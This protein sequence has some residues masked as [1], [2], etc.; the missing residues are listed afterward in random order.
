MTQICVIITAGGSGTRFNKTKKKQ[1]F[2]IFD[3]SILEWTVKAFYEH[4]LIENIIISSPKEDIELLEN[5]LRIYL[6]KV[7]LTAGGKTRQESVFNGL[8]KCPADTKIVLI[9]DA[10]RPFV[11]QEEINNLINKAKLEKAVIPVTKVK[12]TIKK[13]F[14]NYVTETVNRDELVEVHTPQAFDYELI[15]N[16]HQK[17]AKDG[18]NLTDDAGLCEYYGNKVTIVECSNNNIK[19]T[20]PEDLVLATAIMQDFNKK[21]VL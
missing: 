16:L 3:K 5:E 14:D 20:N 15:F 13:F 19:I 8:K 12:Y 4:N 11:Y 2:Q 7:T 10:V 9:H 6:D 17:A 1:Y 18:L 21:D